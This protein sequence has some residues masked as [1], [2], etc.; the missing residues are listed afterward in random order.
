ML[1]AL[2]RGTLRGETHVGNRGLSGVSTRGGRVRSQCVGLWSQGQVLVGS[3]LS[4]QGIR[5]VVLGTGGGRQAGSGG[6]NS[7]AGGW[8]AGISKHPTS[9]PS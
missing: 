8:T 9:P 2:V 7:C 3:S 4:L 6:W 1:V 5:G